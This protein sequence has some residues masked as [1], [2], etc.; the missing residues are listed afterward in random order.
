VVSSLERTRQL[1]G[2]V[3]PE[4]RAAIRRTVRADRLL[5]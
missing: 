5:D 4:H 2:R 3:T 1:F